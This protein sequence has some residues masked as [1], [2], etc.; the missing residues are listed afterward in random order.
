MRVLAS[1]AQHLLIQIVAV[2]AIGTAT[3][4]FLAGRFDPGL[5]GA[6]AVTDDGRRL[7]GSVVSATTGS[8]AVAAPDAAGRPTMDENALR[9]DRL[10]DNATLAMAAEQYFSPPE[11]NARHYYE[12]VLDL[13]PDNARA[14]AGLD[15]LTEIIL[16][17]ATAALAA[18]QLRAAVSQLEAARALRPEHR[19]IPLVERQLFAERTR[20]TATARLTA[21]AGQYD[22][23]QRLLERA[24]RLPVP[25]GAPPIRELRAEIEGLREDAASR[26]ARQALD[27]QTQQQLEAA[28]REEEAAARRR[29]EQLARRIDA[30][31]QEARAAIEED[32]LLSPEWES[33]RQLLAE[34]GYLEADPLVLASLRSAYLN[35]LVAGAA[36]RIEDG[37]FDAAEGWIVEIRDV[38]GEDDPRVPRLREELEEAR[39]QAETLRVAS[40]NEY[41][42]ANYVEPRYPPGAEQLGTEGWVDLEFRV[43]Q[44]G[45]VTDVIVLDSARTGSFRGA[46]VAAV[47]QW[48]ME[49]RTYL[50]RPLSQR[51]RT[52][53]VF[54]LGDE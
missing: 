11:R 38:V 46:A 52:R 2:V 5:T 43:L 31:V 26:A 27:A 50:G 51:V 21:R 29:E 12:A 13:E 42:F 14:N 22:E 35:R 25:P 19:L 18:D 28:R 7:V 1:S 40:I 9:I 17:R 39:F 45:R 24:T 54:Q 3:A 20:L 44:D 37:D 36:Q 4:W 53:L 47:R 10:L 48:R 23:A 41:E 8:V 33:A 30:L 49:P 34:L 6:A 32:R 16:E 15:R